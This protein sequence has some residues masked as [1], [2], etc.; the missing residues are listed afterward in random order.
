M[1]YQNKGNIAVGYDADFAIVNL[2]ES[3]KLENEDLF[4]RH[5]HSPYV[6]MTFKGKVKTT[7]VNG[8]VVYE[9]GN[10]PKA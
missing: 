7:I 4:Y 6:G 1:A 8:E 5:Q 2:N 3:F 9:N 10:F